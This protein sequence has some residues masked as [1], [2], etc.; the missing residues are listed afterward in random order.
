[1][2]A[3]SS[4]TVKKALA[5]LRKDRRLAPVI[6]RVGPPRFHEYSRGDLLHNIL[7]AILAQQLSARVARVIFGR[8]KDQQGKGFPDPRHIL[9]TPDETLR[10]LGFSR[11]KVAAVKALSGA[12][13]SGELDLDALQALPD[14]GVIEALTRVK[15]IGPWTAHMA[16]IFALKRPDVWPA[17]DLGL[18]KSLQ[19]L[20]DLPAVPTTK[21]AEPMGDPWRPYRSYACW[22]LWQVNDA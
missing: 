11:A 10:G 5:R 9:D 3:S 19:V 6:A 14:E 16:L 13:L 7:E 20:M 2:T 17:A 18:R 8:F 12:I 21:E 1:M 22:Y 4:G 15:G